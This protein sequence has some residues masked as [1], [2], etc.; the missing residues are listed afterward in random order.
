MNSP[1][2]TL[3]EGPQLLLQSPGGHQEDKLFT[4]TRQKVGG[5]MHTRRY[6]SL[7]GACGLEPGFQRPHHP[8]GDKVDTAQSP[9]VHH[10]EE[11]LQQVL[12]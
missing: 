8:A 10:T 9:P 3:E 12:C 6:D 2:E 5:I 1:D 4:G 7:V 11:W